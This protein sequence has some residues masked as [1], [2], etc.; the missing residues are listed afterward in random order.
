M[1]LICYRRMQMERI[2]DN[3]VNA[4]WNLFGLTG[5]VEEYLLYR[6]IKNKSENRDEG[7]SGDER[8]SRDEGLSRYEELHYK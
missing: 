6:D 1:K 5:G 2:N 8:F 7:L 3:V 4:A